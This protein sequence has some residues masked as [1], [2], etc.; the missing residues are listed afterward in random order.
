MPAM[1]PRLR[2]DVDLVEIDDEAILYDPV[3]DEVHH[4]N[5]TASLVVQLCDGTATVH[6]TAMEL[7]AAYGTDP[8]DMEQNVRTVVRWL[9]TPQVLLARP[10]EELHARI[11]SPDERARIRMEVPRSS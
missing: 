10:N 6:Q 3:R 1:K 7:A 11:L 9:R 4:L 2:P 8:G 5:P